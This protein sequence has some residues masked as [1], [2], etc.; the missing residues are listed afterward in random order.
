MLTRR[1]DL[2]LSQDQSQTFLPW[3]IALMV[4]L[5]ALALA[6]AMILAN[7]IG[8]WDRDLSG[9]L[10]VQIAPA[11][12]LPARDTD[13]KGKAEGTPTKES[14]PQRLKAAIA[15]LKATPEV[16]NIQ[17]LSRSSVVELL[18]PWLGATAGL[19]D[20][21]MPQVIDV[22]VAPGSQLDIDALSKRLTEAVPGATVDEHRV[23]LDRLILYA[24]TVE[25]I[26]IAVVTLIAL[27]AIGVVVFTTVTRL[28]I[29]K[30]AVSLLHL[31]GAPDDYVAKQFQ[32][33]A[34]RLGLGGGLIGLVF[35][36]V[37]LLG[38]AHAAAGL[39]ESMLPTPSLT[40][41]QWVALAQLPLASGLIAMVTA[42]ITVLRALGRMM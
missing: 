1:T 12:A 6:A 20:L 42:R 3:M 17:P 25:V 16:V 35:A 14:A 36:I 23:W 18:R 38:L 30:S 7:A 13:T 26:S 19:E 8:R 27:V 39:E 37:A 21:P 4:F 29:H 11:D 34:L 10:T 24:W 32:S 33:H 28:T 9:S 41:V 2:P 31:I 22:V 5:V 40:A 15:V